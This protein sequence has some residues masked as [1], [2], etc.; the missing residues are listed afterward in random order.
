M[1]DDL[2]VGI[3]IEYSNVDHEQG[4]QAL[5]RAGLNW[6]SKYDG[7]VSNGGE[8]CSPIL[9]LKD[10]LMANQVGIACEAL[11][12]IGASVSSATGLHVHIGH[13]GGKR[14]ARCIQSFATYQDTLYELAIGECSRHR[15]ENY[16]KRI[17]VSK[18]HSLMLNECSNIDDVKQVW[19]LM[20]ANDRYRGLNLCSLNS[21]GT[22]EFRLFNSTLNPKLIIAYAE[23]ARALAGGEVSKA[24][25]QPK[26]ATFGSLYRQLQTVTR[27]SRR[28]LTA[29]ADNRIKKLYDI[30]A[31]TIPNVGVDIPFSELPVRDIDGYALDTCRVDGY[32]DYR[33]NNCENYPENCDCHC[34]N[35]E[36]SR[37]SCDCDYPDFS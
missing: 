22:V 13:A 36:G 5:A 14:T 35:C 26:G 31:P 19:Q 2:T 9:E 28:M 15:G 32:G 24:P 12:A 8:F 16:A 30:G 37:T 6:T 20:T 34:I 23:M 18:I 33:C 3:E 7:S 27:E 29:V 10:K 25:R 11:S 17:A 1:T 21:H 4:R